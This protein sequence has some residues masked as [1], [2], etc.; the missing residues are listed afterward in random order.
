MSQDKGLSLDGVV[1]RES[2]HGLTKGLHSEVW[3]DGVRKTGH[4]LGL[5]EGHAGAHTVSG[6]SRGGLGEENP[7]TSTCTAPGE[8]QRAKTSILYVGVYGYPRVH[9][10]GV[11]GPGSNITFLVVE[12]YFQV[13][14]FCLWAGIFV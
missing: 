4:S 6:R 14:Y 9:I 5:R 1:A 3:G 2:A 12:Y 13:Y 8:S 7:T 10:C 11:H